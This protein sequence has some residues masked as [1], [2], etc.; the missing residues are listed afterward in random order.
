MR[1]DT[2]C[3]TLLIR[4]VCNRHK[5]GGCGAIGQPLELEP[6][7]SAPEPAPEPQF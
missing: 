1:G 6:E 3:A 7:P 5:A 2:D 4:A